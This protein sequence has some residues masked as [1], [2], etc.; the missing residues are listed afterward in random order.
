MSCPNVL[1]IG[2]FDDLCRRR[3]KASSKE[4]AEWPK[5]PDCESGNGFARSGVRIP[6][7]PPR[8]P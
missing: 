7:S 8:V 6:P 3:C 4:V 5:A 2:M 1:M